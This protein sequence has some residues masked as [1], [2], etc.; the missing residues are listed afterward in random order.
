MSIQT[1]CPHCHRAYSFVQE[2][3]GKKARCKQC[4]HIFVIK[5]ATAPR[6]E[7]VAAVRATAGVQ[8]KPRLAARR[9]TAPSAQVQDKP[10][11]SRSSSRPQAEKQVYPAPRRRRR[12]KSR[13]SSGVLPLVVGG[14]LLLLLV[15]AGGGGLWWHARSHGGPTA[16]TGSWP[17]PTLLVGNQGPMP[18]DEVVTLHILG[19]ADPSTREAI[20][21]KLPALADASGGKVS[22]VGSGDRLAVLLGPVRD[23]QVCAQKVDVG[24]VQSVRGRVITIAVSQVGGRY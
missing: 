9:G 1:T 19:V 13:D 18:A 3:A 2:S 6:E 4:D 12:R 8:T 16:D 22:K 11:P 10:A 17:T 5:R 21:H 24:T 14:V 7:G 23:P 15:V 20:E